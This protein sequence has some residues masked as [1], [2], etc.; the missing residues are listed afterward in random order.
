VAHEDSETAQHAHSVCDYMVERLG[1]RC[2]FTGQMW[3]FDVLRIPESRELAARGAAA[4]DV[5]MV[6]S[7]GTGDLPGEVKAW[8]ELWL[9]DKADHQTL[10]ALF[11]CPRTEA[12]QYWPIHEYLAGVA[13]RAQIPFFAEPDAWPGKGPHQLSLPLHSFAEAGKRFLLPLSTPAIRR[14]EVAHWGINE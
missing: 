6:S 1:P 9:R 12:D 5:V 3:G 10:L 2:R 14:S 4:A 11:D 13:Q 7:H 8:I